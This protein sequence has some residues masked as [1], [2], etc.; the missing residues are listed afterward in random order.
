MSK[1]STS[2]LKIVANTLNDLVKGSSR[3]YG[4]HIYRF[5]LSIFYSSTHYIKQT[6]TGFIV[7]KKYVGWR[8]TDENISVPKTWRV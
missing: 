7:C 2:N 1:Y 4:T 3:I 8:R 5:N 6:S